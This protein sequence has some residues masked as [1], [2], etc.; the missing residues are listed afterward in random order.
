M[1]FDDLVRKIFGLGVMQE[2]EGLLKKLNYI[3]ATEFTTDLPYVD[4][5]D[6]VHKAELNSGPRV[7]GRCRIHGS[8]CL[9]LDQESMTSI[10]EYLGAFWGTRLVD[11]FSFTL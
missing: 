2:V 9:C 3:T 7:C 8:T 1:Y 4:F 10:R 11:L 6:R 5:L